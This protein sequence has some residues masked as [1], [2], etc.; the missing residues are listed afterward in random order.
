MVQ[1]LFLA[2]RLRIP[3]KKLAHVLNVNT[4]CPW[5][6]VAV[7]PELTTATYIVTLDQKEATYAI[8]IAQKLHIPGETNT[9][10]FPS[11]DRSLVY[12]ADSTEND[13]RIREEKVGFLVGNG[14]TPCCFCGRE[15]ASYPL[16]Y[17]KLILF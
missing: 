12:L 13:R 1:W 9:I 17:G 4:L 11:R 2:H 15:C 8:D 10:H 7:K 3:I 16:F 6:V 14:R 5:T